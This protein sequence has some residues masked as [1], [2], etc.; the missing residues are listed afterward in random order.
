MKKRLSLLTLFI[1]FALIVGCSN[2]A[3]KS[4]T[5]KIGTMPSVDSLPLAIAQEKGLFEKYNVKVELQVFNSP[6]QR[7]SALQANEIQG[8]IADSVALG[9]FQNANLDM[10]VVSLSSGNFN[11]IVREDANI[12]DVKDLKGKKVIISENT[13]IDF[14]NDQ[15]L[16]QAGLTSKD[17]EKVVIAAVPA[18]LEA[19]NNKQA[20]A[21]ILP[22]P[23]DTF[24]TK[25]GHKIIKT[26]ANEEQQ[27]ALLLLHNDILTNNKQG[28]GNFVK[29]YNEA[30]DYLNNVDQA[31]IQELI[32]TT[33]G[34][35]KND[36]K[37]IK[38]PNFMPITLPDAT[39]VNEALAW[40]K[41]KGIITKEINAEDLMVEIN[42]TFK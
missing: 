39:K 23:Y 28:V 25:Q 1:C 4:T 40:S 20:D 16:Q 6:L 11:L 33:V 31:T 27:I 12:K 24:A 17:V 19:L 42:V 26:I 34:Y 7:D 5:I 2:K 36:I 9:L 21:I 30:V 32:I 10:K 35:S 22:A 37:T 29:A 15:L 38:L 13:V 3:E 8:V 14:L 41:D 18:R